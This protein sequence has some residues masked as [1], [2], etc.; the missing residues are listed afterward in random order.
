MARKTPHQ[1]PPR[2]A[3]VDPATGIQLIERQIDAGKGL[4]ASRPLTENAYDTWVMI[5][6]QYIE[7]AFGEKSAADAAFD[8]S[9]SIGSWPMNA[10]EAWW[11]AKRVEK[12]NARLS[13]LSG[14]IELLKTEQQLAGPGK[15]IRPKHEGLGHR[16]FLVHGRDDGALHEVARFLE[17]LRQDV[18]VLREQ[19][20]QGRTIIEKFEDY[21][22]VGFAVVLLAPDD[23]GGLEG[24]EIRPRAR[25]NVILE[26]GYFLGRLGRM[27]VC[28][29][30]RG[31]V[32][33]PSDYS[34][35]VYVPIDDAGGWRLMLA[36]ELKA[37]G[38]DVDLNS[39][40]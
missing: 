25:Q 12:L 33:I 40:M 38:F 22:D 14:L 21:G 31:G 4:L 7:K 18:I 39:A 19:P 37:A 30:H 3:T 23:R 1:A 36:R 24:G 34:G 27:R 8:N 15:A 29:L 28:A 35:V 11:A 20:N 26:L 6:A 10:G 5:T 32:E 2:G 17:R 16:I 9:G 13:C